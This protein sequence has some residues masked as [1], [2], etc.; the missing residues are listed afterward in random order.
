[1]AASPAWRGWAEGPM[2]ALSNMSVISDI[3]RWKFLASRAKSKI[4]SPMRRAE[5]ERD[6]CGLLAIGD[7][8]LRGVLLMKAKEKHIITSVTNAAHL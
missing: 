2:L 6:M 4:R 3:L 8:I 1:M 7:I 5:V